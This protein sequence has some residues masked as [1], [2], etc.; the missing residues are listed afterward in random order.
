MIDEYP[1]LAVATMALHGAGIGAARIHALLKDLRIRPTIT[2]W[3]RF[4]KADIG[5]WRTAPA[6]EVEMPIAPLRWDPLPLPNESVSF[7]EGVR[8]MTTAGDA[9][10]QA[11]MGTHVYLITRS[12]QDEYFY[13]ADGEML[14]VPQQGDLRLWTE[15][16]II[17]I[18]PGE[19]AVIPR[20]VK[21]RVELPGGPARGY[22]C[23]NYGGA[24]TLPERGPIGA[25]CLAN[26]RDF[27]CP[28]AAFEDRETRSRVVIKWCGQF[29]ETWI[30]HS[31]LDIVAW[32]GNYC[33]Y[34][35]DLRTYSP[36]GAILFDHPDPSIFTVLT[37][38]SGQEGTANID[39]VLFRERWM[40]AEHSFRPPWYHKNIMSE[41]M[42]N[43][44]GIYDAKPQGFAPGGISLHNCMLPHGPDRDAFEG[45]SN[46]ELRP[47]KLDNTMSF[48]FET[49]FPQHLTEFAAK[50]APMQQEYIEVWQRLEKKFDGTPGVK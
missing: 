16:G 35:Y 34:K 30:G 33:A 25:N 44:Y 45:A 2:H 42:G 29:H 48:M 41:L 19:I 15:F 21:F 37:A 46:A 4:Q 38:P 12:M 39:F 23:E 20:G 8:T 22:L 32:H 5:L 10:S 31:P 26:P 28:V 24:L 18:E 17:D 11:G 6:P 27:K 3:G 43:I 50:E 7:L 9:G 1:V 47:E 40:V 36:V 13:N 49:R 14:F